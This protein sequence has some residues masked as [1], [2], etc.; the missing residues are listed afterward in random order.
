M[1]SS[2]VVCQPPTQVFQSTLCEDLE[3]KAQLQSVKI[4][5]LSSYEQG[6]TIFRGPKH[7]YIMEIRVPYPIK[8]QYFSC[9]LGQNSLLTI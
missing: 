1:C 7:N 3:H 2:S 5:H 9:F 8:G 6:K 4:K